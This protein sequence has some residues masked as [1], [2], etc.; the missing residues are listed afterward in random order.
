MEELRDPI[1]TPRTTDEY[2]QYNINMLP[3]ELQYEILN[4]LSLEEL[5][6]VFLAIED[7]YV[8]AYARRLGE[9]FVLWKKM[10]VRKLAAIGDL[11]GVKWLHAHGADILDPKVMENA[12]MSGNIEMVQWLHAKGANILTPYVNVCGVMSG[13]VELIQWLHSHGSNIIKKIGRNG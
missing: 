11:E 9:K 2:E 3:N 10:G 4:G 13:N 1:I 6:K 8:R 7:S 5:R 12:A